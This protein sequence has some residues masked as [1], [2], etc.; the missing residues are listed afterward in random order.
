MWRELRANGKEIS[1]GD[2]VHLCSPLWVGLDQLLRLEAS[3]NVTRSAKVELSAI[4][5]PTHLF[6][7]L[8]AVLDDGVGDL[9]VGHPPAEARRR[10][11][12][13]YVL[14]RQKCSVRSRSDKYATLPSRAHRE[15]LEGELS[16]VEHSA[17]T[18]RGRQDEVSCSV[19]VMRI[20]DGDRPCRICTPSWPS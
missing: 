16:S 8:A 13:R 9:D 20:G 15:K 19:K 7:R 10:V 18:L 4:S 1:R 14:G 17:Q 6:E 3:T 11:P 12:V 5:G 2:G